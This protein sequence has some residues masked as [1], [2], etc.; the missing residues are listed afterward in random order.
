MSYRFADSL[1]AGPV[2]RRPDSDRKLCVYIYY[3]IW[4]IS[5]LQLVKIIFIN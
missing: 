3:N 5:G 1:R 2:Q 4:Y